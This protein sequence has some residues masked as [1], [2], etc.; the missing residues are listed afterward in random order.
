[1]ALPC[2]DCS[3]ELPTP[4]AKRY[5]L[6]FPIHRESPLELR[7]S[8]GLTFPPRAGVLVPKTQ[9]IGDNHCLVLTIAV[10]FMLSVVQLYQRL[11]V[12]A[13][14]VFLS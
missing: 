1:M 7:N 4:T 12:S 8:V 10:A 2:H 14:M 5:G 13:V 9:F 11:F 6:G 3:S